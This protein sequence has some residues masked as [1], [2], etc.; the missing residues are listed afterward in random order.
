MR[1]LAGY[2]VKSSTE[3]AAGWLKFWWRAMTV[4][5]TIVTETETSVRRFVGSGTNSPWAV[6]TVVFLVRSGGRI[7]DVNGS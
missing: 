5:R 6:S 4:P 7:I 3:A 1:K 2:S